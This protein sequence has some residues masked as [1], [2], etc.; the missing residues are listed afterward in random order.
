MVV[1][2]L[3]FGTISFGHETRL[4]AYHGKTP[5]HYYMVDWPSRRWC[6]WFI[7]QSVYCYWSSLLV[8]IVPTRSNSM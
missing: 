8:Y 1:L 3:P 5:R 2:L 7:P 4:Q 6:G